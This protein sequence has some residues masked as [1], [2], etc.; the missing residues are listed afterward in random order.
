M[1]ILSGTTGKLPQLYF[2]P[3]CVY[4]WYVTLHVYLCLCVKC[5]PNIITV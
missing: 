2:V 3:L 1:A 4:L 5:V